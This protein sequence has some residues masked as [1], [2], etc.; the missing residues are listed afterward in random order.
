MQLPGCPRLNIHVV[1]PQHTFHMPT[2]A[3]ALGTPPLST[4]INANRHIF[5]RCR[6]SMPDPASKPFPE[7]FMPPFRSLR[8]RSYGPCLDRLGL[9]L[10]VRFLHRTAL[11]VLSAVAVASQ[12]STM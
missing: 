6:Q 2:C 7:Q 3:P 10:G 12:A 5:H 8:G 4:P 11:C 9:G 1:S